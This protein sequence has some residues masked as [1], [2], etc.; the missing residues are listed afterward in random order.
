MSETQV[1]NAV[2]PSVQEY[3]YFCS[4]CNGVNKFFL[5]NRERWDKCEITAK[6]KECESFSKMLEEKQ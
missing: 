1:K 4:K 2:R 5:T 6:C 3:D